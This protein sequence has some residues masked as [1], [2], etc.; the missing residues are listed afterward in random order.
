MHSL[1]IRIAN[2][3]KTILLQTKQEWELLYFG[4]IKLNYKTKYPECQ[5]SYTGCHVLAFAKA[6]CYTFQWLQTGGVISTKQTV[7]GLKIHNFLVQY[8]SG[9]IELVEGLLSVASQETIKNQRIKNKI[10]RT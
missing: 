3:I 9:N 7:H 1:T 2:A 10:S 8:L 6:I 5:F 4:L